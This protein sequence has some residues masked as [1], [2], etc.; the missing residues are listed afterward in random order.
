MSA[1]QYD[2]SQN[3]DNSNVFRIIVSRLQRTYFISG[4]E[5]F[6]LEP[7]SRDFL[8]GLKSR[9]VF[10]KWLKTHEHGYGIRIT[11]TRELYVEYHASFLELL[12][13][14]ALI[15][16]EVPGNVNAC[17][18]I[19]CAG[20]YVLWKYLSQQGITVTWR[21]GDI[22]LFT[23]DNDTVD[24]IISVYRSIVA[25]PLGFDATSV[26]KETYGD[27]ENEQGETVD[28]NR[29]YGMIHYG[30][31]EN[32]I[33]QGENGNR[34]AGVITRMHLRK[35]LPVALAQCRNK[36]NGDRNILACLDSIEEKY[37]RAF[38]KGPMMLIALLRC[39]PL[40]KV[41]CRCHYFCTE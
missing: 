14:R 40:I 30:G 7:V 34:N 8:H 16:K 10:T 32:M 22:D 3:L 12:F 13:L 17:K 1:S 31:N 18:N 25:S 27:T 4:A 35:L 9:D 28:Y 5:L 38:R 2:A 24:K 26:S 39:I 11:K 36:W 41:L 6:A 33:H 19:V 15:P 23:D 21:P 29:D 20:G 37:Q